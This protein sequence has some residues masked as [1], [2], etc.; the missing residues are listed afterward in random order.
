M[1]NSIK[2]NSWVALSR[3]SK[4]TDNI[5]FEKEN[6]TQTNVKTMLSR[7]RKIETNKK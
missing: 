2:S 5:S 6:Y 7:G 4:F 3:C 1:N